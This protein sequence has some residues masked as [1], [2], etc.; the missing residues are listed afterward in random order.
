MIP[1]CPP[2]GLCLDGIDR[3]T[4]AGSRACSGVCVCHEVDEE[5][6]CDPSMSNLALQHPASVGD[7]RSR[8]RSSLLVCLRVLSFRFSCVRVAF[9]QH[10][11]EVE[12]V[13]DPGSSVIGQ[14]RQL[15]TV[16]YGVP[17]V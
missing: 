2:S 13:D 15:Q 12:E 4:V 3:G 16:S 7:A 6:R 8:L 17:T 9:R 1:G 11:I 14:E 5:F 10:D